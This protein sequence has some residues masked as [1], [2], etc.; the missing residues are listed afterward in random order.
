MSNV[1]FEA[2]QFYG[3]VCIVCKSPINVGDYYCLTD[4]GEVIHDYCF[5]TLD[6]DP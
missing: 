5:E 3:D 6:C 4:E 2:T 1:I